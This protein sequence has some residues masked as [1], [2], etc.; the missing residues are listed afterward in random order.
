MAT[1]M[2]EI[3]SGAGESGARRIR[4][5]LDLVVG[6]D[7]LETDQFLLPHRII[8][9]LWLREAGTHRAVVDE[10]VSRL[11]ERA[12]LGTLPYLLMHI[13]RDDATTDRWDDAETAYLEGIRLANETGQTTDLAVSQA[14]L[15]WLYARQ[16]R[17][18]Q[19]RE[20]VNAAVPLCLERHVNV[21]TAWLDLAQGDL[22]VGL[23]NLTVAVLHYERLEERLRTAGLSD[24]D[25]SSAPELTEAYLHLGRPE[26][27]SR[28]AEKF[29]QKAVAK[30][31]PWSLA[32]AERA[33]GL[34]ATG[35]AVDAHF[36]T[37]LY[38]HRRTPDRYEMARTELAYGAALRRMRQRVNARPLLRSALTTFE[39]LGAVPWA[40]RAAR[41]L[42]ATGQTPHRR[43]ASAIDELTPQER[44]ISQLLARG[45]TTRE[46]AAA[47]FI[48][49]KTVE[50]H[51]R[52]VYLKLAISSREA[53]AEAFPR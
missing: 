13:A 11:R 23:G 12:A 2:A 1:G 21:G 36:T 51:L 45:S 38:L 26:A 16:G 47:L 34:C 53:L 46:T 25:Q 50:Y 27:A 49:P 5:A 44:Q 3:L 37:A 43:A 33:L 35:A 24:P 31:Q 42:E 7:D 20:I 18:E 10:A 30:G 19:C 28:M 9:I 14:G 41:E 32:R 48:S 40:D 39:E 8:G 15:A 52:H 29:K 17:S 4:A 6:V 22:E